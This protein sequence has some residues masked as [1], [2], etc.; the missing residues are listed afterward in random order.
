MGYD[1]YIHNPMTEEEEAAH[2]TASEAFDAAVRQRDGLPQDLPEYQDAQHRLDNARARMEKEGRSTELSRA[3]IEARAQVRHLIV[4]HPGYEAAQQKV[5]AAYEEMQTA[6]V[7]YFRL[8][9]HGMGAYRTVM[10]QLGMLVTEYNVPDF[11]ELPDGLTWED[12]DAVEGE[13]NHG[14]AD[15]LPVKAAAAAYVKEL[16]AHLAW[17]P[18]PASGIAMHKL[19]SND[20]WLVTPAEIEAA[21]ASYR[22]HSGPEVMTLLRATLGDDA[23]SH[24]YWIEWVTYLERARV[25][26]GFKVH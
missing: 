26:G 15:G 19:G 20:G 17:H 14:T 7:S 21:L 25:R 12:I 6:N 24:S 23:D 13:A 10:H 1:M 5:D 9:I 11:P 18:E 2:R 4:S 16:N 3:V 8:N 22:T